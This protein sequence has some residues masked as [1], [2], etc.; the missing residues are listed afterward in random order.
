MG[1]AR[2][3]NKPFQVK[4]EKL[5]Y[6][7]A[8]LGRRERKVVFVPFS[9]PGD[10]LLVRPVEEKKTYLR[11]EIVR[12]FEPGMGRTEPP[13][14]YFGKCGGCH[15]QQLGYLH[16]IEAKRRILEELFHHRF[17]QTIDLPIIMRACTRPYGYRSRARVQ[18]RGCGAGSKLGFFRFRSRSVEDIAQC[19]L[20]RPSLNEALSSLRQY[21]LKVDTDFRLREVDMAAS[22]EEGTWTTEMVGVA[23]NQELSIAIGNSRGEEVILKRKI[24]QFCY[25][26]KASVFFQ[27]NDF[28][29]ME[30]VD[31]VCESAKGAG[32][33]SALDLFSGVGLFSLPLA[34]QFNKVVAV[35]N[36]QSACRLCAANASAAGLDNVEAVC[37]DAAEWMKAVPQSQRRKFDIIVLDPPRTGAGAVV[38]DQIVKWAPPVIIYVSCD[39]QTL[40]RDL[41]RI[42]ARDYTIDLVE[43]LDMFPQTYHFETVVRLVRK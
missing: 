8:G 24:G 40:V 3:L 42:P 1:N 33:G 29:V 41:A 4:I 11:A 22:E 13:C 21:Q 17:P 14:E 19:L 25:S 16:Q 15:L 18:L 20:F 31:L 43:G 35:D 28:M 26:V 9:V 12:V 6:G 32:Y 30:L 39:P 10:R 27:P 38:M 23:G 37:A 2:K 36:S 7:G 34:N 5:V